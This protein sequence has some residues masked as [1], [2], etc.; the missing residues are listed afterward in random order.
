MPSGFS[1]AH[2]GKQKHKNKGAYSSLFLPKNPKNLQPR[3]KGGLIRG[4]GLGIRNCEQS[5][6]GF[7][8]IWMSVQYLE[9]GNSRGYASSSSAPAASTG[10]CVLSAAARPTALRLY[11]RG[12][13]ASEAEAS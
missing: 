7:V 9:Y 8:N 1:F 12:S 10:R 4:N 5:L 2:D 13:S 3:L 11:E 6:F